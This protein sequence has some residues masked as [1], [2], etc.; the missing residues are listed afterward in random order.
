MSIILIF[1]KLGTLINYLGPLVQ[2]GPLG[3]MGPCVPVT[4]VLGTLLE[5]KFHLLHVHASIFMSPRPIP[6]F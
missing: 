6:T 3:I 1:P 5:A 2:L 4:G